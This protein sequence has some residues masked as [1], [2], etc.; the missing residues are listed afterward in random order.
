MTAERTKEFGVLLAVG[1]NKIKLI[2][3]TTI[4]AILISLIGAISGI[5]VSIPLV[6][7]FKNNPIRFTGELAEI[8]LKFGVEPIIPL[9]S[10]Y[11]IFIAQT[12]VVLTIALL[13]SLYPINYIR[14]LKP[15]EGMR[16]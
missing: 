6:L 3:I 10:D 2:S 11:S 7:Y 13:S 1:V 9:S 12:F 4:E 15:V 8:S 5:F 16:L 14:K